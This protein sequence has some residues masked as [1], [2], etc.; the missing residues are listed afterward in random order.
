[1]IAAG[2]A[3]VR[4]GVARDTTTV[5]DELVDAVKVASPLYFAVMTSVPA[6]SASLNEAT[7]FWISDEPE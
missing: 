5:V 7:P 4:V 6:G 2:A 1:V 3:Q